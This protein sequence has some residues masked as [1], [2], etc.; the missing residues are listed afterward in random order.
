MRF[1]SAW[2]W[3]SRFAANRNWPSRLCATRSSGDELAHTAA[4]KGS[5]CD[6]VLR[7]LSNRAAVLLL[8]VFVGANFVAATFLTW[9]TQFIYEKFSMSLSVSSTLSTAWSLSSLA[10]SALRR[11]ACRLAGADEQGGPDQG[12]E[13]G[14]GSGSAFRVPG[15]VVGNA[16]P[17]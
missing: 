6:K 11:C 13:P 12:P 10:G 7:I 8:C 15:R 4:E 5:L 3:S 14:P 2:A 16:C 9:L 17:C 1:S